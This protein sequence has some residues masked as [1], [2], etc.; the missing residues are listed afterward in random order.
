MSDTFFG[1][2]IAGQ[3]VATISKSGK[4][5]VR[6]IVGG[7]GDAATATI[8]TVIGTGILRDGMLHQKDRINTTNSNNSNATGGNPSSTAT[9]TSN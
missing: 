6:A 2:N 9:A 1:Q 3:N 7:L 8:P 4:T 5:I